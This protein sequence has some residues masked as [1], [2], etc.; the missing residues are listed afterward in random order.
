MAID[1]GDDTWQV[2]HTTNHF[3]NFTTWPKTQTT[4]MTTKWGVPW[5]NRN[6]LYD[7]L[8]QEGNLDKSPTLKDIHRQSTLPENVTFCL[9][10]TY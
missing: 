3:S 2:A 5:E 8:G 4:G 6:G 9:D 10:L 1:Y 7:S